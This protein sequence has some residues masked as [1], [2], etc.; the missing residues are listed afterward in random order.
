MFRPL[1]AALCALALL[2]CGNT[3]QLS[4]NPQLTQHSQQV[5]RALTNAQGRLLTPQDEAQATGVVVDTDGTEHVHFNRRHRGLRVVGGDFLI[6]NGAGGILKETT[7][8]LAG[9]PSRLNLLP[10]LTAEAAVRSAQG[11]APKADTKGVELVILAHERAPTLAYE[12][13]TSDPS[14]PQELHVFI[15]ARTGAV[16]DKWD[17]IE[18][19]AAVGSGKSLYSGTVSLSTNSLASGFEL[20]DVVRGNGF[21]TRDSLTNAIFTDADNNWGNGANSDRVSAGVDA[22]YGQMVT[23]DYYKNVHGRN[24]IDNAGNVGY[25]VVHYGTNY[26]NAFWSDGCFCM[27]YGDGDGSVLSSLVSLDVAGHEMTH[28]VTSRTAGLIYSGESGGLNEGTSDIFG[29]MVEF[30]ANSIYDPGDYLIGERI[31][32]PARSGDALRYMYNPS[33]DGAS[34]N[35]WSSTVGN[36][37]VHYSSGVANHFFYLLAVGSNGSPAS[38]TCNGTTVTGIGRA[39]AEKIW[40]RALTVYMTSSTNYAAARVAT[41]NAAR[42]LYGLNSARYNA[43]AAAWSAVNV[44]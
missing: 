39:S 11:L 1:I 35:C 2:G 17:G 14:A 21:A 27:T 41:L 18:T 3:T 10:D 23:Y 19:A 20:R 28:G 36:L 8:N 7:S 26:N 33:R 44:N 42:D 38:P 31:Y 37:D 22:H 34:A 40:Y 43:V 9:D 5:S 6:H 15:D 4:S 13:V 32:T 25:S 16:L 12:V 29:T 24:G 30:Y